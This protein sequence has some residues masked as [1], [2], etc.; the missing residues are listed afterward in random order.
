MV[1]N[2]GYTRVEVV[3]TEPERIKSVQSVFLVD[4]GSWYSCIPPSLAEKTDLKTV[5]KTALTLADERKVEV[6]LSPAYI[7]VMDREVATLVAVLNV[8][9]PLLGVETLE[10]LGLKLD[11]TT[12]RL[13]ITRP[14]TTLLVYGA[15]P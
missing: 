4:S 11:P 9:E 6:N 8:P 7:K 15:R 10:A 3:I 13:E 12:S 14:Y 5:M 2:L 1:Q